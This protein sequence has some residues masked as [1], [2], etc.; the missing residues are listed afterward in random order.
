[1][2]Q[3][4]IAYLTEAGFYPVDTAA[5]R[6]HCGSSYEL[7]AALGKGNI[8]CY[9]VDNLY[10]IVVSDFVF[11]CDVTAQFAH[12]PFFLIGLTTAT[13]P[14]QQPEVDQK[15]PSLFTYVG[16]DDVFQ[17]GFERGTLVRNVSVS[18]LPDFY[19]DFLP[20]RYP[21]ISSL[22]PIFTAIND[23]DAIPEVTEVL[24]QL[25]SFRPVG[26]IARLYYDSK[27][28]ELFS[29]MLQREI[30]RQSLPVDNPVPA[31]DLANLHQVMAYLNAHYTKEIYLKTL[32]RQA[33]MSQ[34]KLTALFKQVYGT[35]ISD[36][37]RRLRINLAKEMLADGNRKIAS[38]AQTVGY[39]FHGNFSAAFKYATGLTP[40]AYRKTVR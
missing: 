1:M 14:N 22:E 21:L 3:Q 11:N 38:I 6:R 19:T 4:Y 39:R 31:C 16:Q 5:T 17:G 32:A 28:T 30:D 34:T 40:K 20:G 15:H 25:S 7:D 12:S 35:T 26:N 9:G 23:N 13:H 33:G 37:I 24:H 18:F 8:W 27:V 2:F 36:H 29:M 10:G